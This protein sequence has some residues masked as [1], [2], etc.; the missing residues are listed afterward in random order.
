MRPVS[1]TVD[2][3]AA[4]F[5]CRSIA[6]LVGR[7]ARIDSARLDT[8][9]PSQCPRPDDGRRQQPSGFYSTSRLFRKS[10]APRCATRLTSPRRRKFASPHRSCRSGRGGPRASTH[11]CRFSTCAGCRPATSKRRSPRCWA[12]TLRTYH[13]RRGWYRGHSN[14]L[15]ETRFRKY[16]PRLQADCRLSNLFN[17]S[18][19]GLS[20]RS[21][22]DAASTFMITAGR[23]ASA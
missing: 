9:R 2:E 7:R 12:R 11:C 10:G 23:S 5:S 15:H 17:W 6:R 21:L 14:N 18:C 8:N 19:P 3:G 4:I 1:T 16:A 20:A 13:R 22:N